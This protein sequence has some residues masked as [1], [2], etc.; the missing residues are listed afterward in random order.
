M[1][2]PLLSGVGVFK[3]YEQY[4][5]SL[6]GYSSIT[7]SLLFDIDF[8]F[9]HMKIDLTEILRDCA[10]GTIFYSPIFGNVEFQEVFK[11]QII[12]KVCKANGGIASFDKTGR[13]KMCKFISHEV[14]LFPSEAQRSW[15]CFAHNLV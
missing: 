11:D 6:K 3:I 10:K 13:Y 8:T 2:F 4:I 15:R 7:Y 1:L 12:T 9:K 14:A 5:E